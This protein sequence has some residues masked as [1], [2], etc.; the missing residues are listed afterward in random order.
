MLSRFD[1]YPIHQTPL[2]IAVPASGDRNVYDRYWF[3]GYANDGEF[4]FGAGMALYPH[5]GVMDCGFSIVRDGEPHAFHGSRRAPRDPSETAVGPFRIEVIEPMRRLRVILEENDTGIACELEFR[6]RT[7]C[8]D[9][10]RQTM[11][12]GTR[13][14][15]D[16]TRFAQFGLWEGEIRYDGKTLAVDPSRGRGTKDRSTGMTIV[17]TSESS[18]TPTVR[19]GTGREPSLRSTRTP[20]PFPESRTPGWC[21]WW[22][23]NTGWNTSPEPAGREVPR[24][25]CWRATVSAT[26]SN[27]NRSSAS[28]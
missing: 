5:L 19:C 2:P 7:A 20:R 25:L 17:V 24:S 26:T 3:N 4:Y 9:E 13:A 18:K 10:G 27:S 28:A 16:A 15:M 22:A 11:M 6:A 12:E 14:M 21:P 1:D 23:A 8:I